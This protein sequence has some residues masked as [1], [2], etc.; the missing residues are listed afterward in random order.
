VS[1]LLL[2]FSAFSGLVMENMTHGPGWRF[3][4]IGRRIERGAFMVRLLRST[5][6]GADDAAVLDAVLEVADSAMTYRSRYLGTMALMPVLD[7][8]MTDETNPRSIVYQ[9]A[10]L[11]E[12]VKRLPRASERPLLAPEAKTVLRALSQVRCADVTQL[13]QSD[14]AG[15][16]A[17]LDELLHEL[18]RALPLLAEQLTLGYLAHAQASF[19]L[20]GPAERV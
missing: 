10:M 18:E 2:G 19:S 12:H 15:R 7:L 6:V 14:G 11:E 16:H 8:L 5:L 9:L 3:A 4:D 20:G 13:A 1:T 17:A